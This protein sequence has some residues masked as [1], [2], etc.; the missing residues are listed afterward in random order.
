[1][2]N[3]SDQSKL[4]FFKTEK[5][6]YTDH[7]SFD[8]SKCPRPHFCMG[9][10]TSGSGEFFDCERNAS[11]EV[12]KG[13]IIFVPRTSRYVSKWSSQGDISYISAHFIFD[14]KSVFSGNKK[15]L[16]QKVAVEDFDKTLCDFEYM[17]DN[18]GA[19]GFQ[20]LI[21]LSKFFAIL[22]K[23]LP[24]LETEDENVSDVRIEKALMFVRAHY[25]E[26]ITVEDLAREANMSVSRFF[27]AFKKSTGITPVEYIN[28]YRVSRAIVLLI[29]ENTA[30]MSI[31]EISESVGFE[32]SAYFRRV[33]KKL[34]MKNPRDYKKTS[35]EI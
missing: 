22:G 21:V 9:L 18:Y 28:N 1:M 25:K 19:D 29:S 4:L 26:E 32:S 3:I 30:D 24:K 35:M 23:I 8:A 31:E 13:D 5:Y 12:K 34:T 7:H 16:L 6:H 2:S 17:L 14:D 11:V 10:V 33:F 15:F 20:N 27:P